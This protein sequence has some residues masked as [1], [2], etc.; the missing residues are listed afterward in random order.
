MSVAPTQRTSGAL[1]MV[2][3]TA[4]AASAMR[5]TF[6]P[7]ISVC[8]LVGV[9]LL[10]VWVGAIPKFRGMRWFFFIGAAALAWGGA[11]SFLETERSVGF[12]LLMTNS[13][14]LLS[15][16]VA[17]G[18]LLWSRLEIGSSW[19]V[20]WFGVGALVNVALAGPNPANLWKYSLA[21]PV[22][23]AL[24]GLTSKLWGRK[25]ELASLIFVAGVS[26]V[27]DSR[28]FTSFLLI[29][30]AAVIW[31]LRP[32]MANARRRPVQAL[33][34]LVL[35]VVGAYFLIQALLLDGVLGEAA[36]QRSQAQ[37]DATGSL[38][39]GGRPEMGAAGALLFERPL[40]YGSGTAPG[41]KDIL[42][43]KTGMSELNYNPN[44][45]YVEVFMF[46]G[47]FEVHS[48]LG[49][50]W[51]MF[52]PLGALLIMIIV[53]YGIYSSAG[54]LSTRTASA[55]LVLLVALG[56]WDMLFSPW[57][58]SYRTLSLLIALASLP[59]EATTRERRSGPDG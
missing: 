12:Y 55:A 33:L 47:H 46:G 49:D 9:V 20:M 11:L 29:A 45:R 42:T 16:L 21:I 15:M 6:G 58:T 7:G 32:P 17:A 34:G 56:T 50:M 39:T 19:T 1:A 23:L 44:N 52:G 26:A 41:S 3:A 54:A 2:P 14:T 36:Q 10:P 24:L 27:S 38:I 8:L 43:G 13:L 25:G 30:A 51:I 57:L 40:G 53:G 48:V 4:A 28:S 5:T 59:V 18:M 22:T 35:L 31:Q 37:L